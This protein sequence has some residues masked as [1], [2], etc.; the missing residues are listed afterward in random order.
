MGSYA[1]FKM[2]GKDSKDDDFFGKGILGLW[3]K[4]IYEI[5]KKMYAREQISSFVNQFEQ[6]DSNFNQEI[7]QARKEAEDLFK[8][9]EQFRALAYRAERE[10]RRNSFSLDTIQKYVQ[11]LEE[12]SKRISKK[13]KEII[14]IIKEM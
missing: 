11:L 10:I 6:A 14:Q 8:D 4:F 13:K 5:R 12:K 3:Q 7:V 2:W 9:I 1:Y